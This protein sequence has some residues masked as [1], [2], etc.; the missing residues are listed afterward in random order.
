[1]PYDDPHSAPPATL[2]RDPD[3]AA[4]AFSKAGIDPRFERLKDRKA[5]SLE[6][7]PQPGASRA[8]RWLK[9]SGIPASFARESALS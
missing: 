3:E 6:I 7:R 5:F 8:G 2:I 1:M 9:S 4:E